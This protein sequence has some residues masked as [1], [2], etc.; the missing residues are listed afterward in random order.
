MS[1]WNGTSKV[2]KLGARDGEI[3]ETTV[4]E[5]VDQHNAHGFYI[6]RADAL[7]AL[8]VDILRK[9]THHDLESAR[10]KEVLEAVRREAKDQ[11]ALE[12]KRAKPGR[13]FDREAT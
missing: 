1:S 4:R 9:L 2:W 11:H 12:A 3:I 10:L 8:E 13:M 6:S 5:A 7:D